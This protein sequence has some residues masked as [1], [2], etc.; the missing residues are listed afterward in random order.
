MDAIKLL[1]AASASLPLPEVADR[2]LAAARTHGA[3]LDDQTL[4]LI[5]RT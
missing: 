4:L 1:L 5:R 2:L 3:Q